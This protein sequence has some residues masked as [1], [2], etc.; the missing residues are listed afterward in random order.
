MPS[1]CFIYPP[2][3]AGNRNSNYIVLELH[4]GPEY[5]AITTDE[6]GNNRVFKTREHAEVEAADC[7]D[8]LVVE[9]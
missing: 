3:P 2:G 6:N 5:A 7:Q 9:L 1:A 8:G 4:G